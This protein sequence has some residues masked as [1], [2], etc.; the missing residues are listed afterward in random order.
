M[1]PRPAVIHC[2]SPVPE[3]VARFKTEVEG[4]DALLFV[5]PEHSRTS[6]A[7]LKNAIDWGARPWGKTSWP[8]KAAAVIGTSPGVISSAIEQQHLRAVLGNQGLHVVGSEAYIRFTPDLIDT[9]GEVS[10]ESVRKFLKSFIDRFAAF[11]G[12]FAGHAEQRAA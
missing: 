11:A 3:T 4:S 8:N 2:T 9:Q 1:M 7:V 6:R 5:T 10:D 12:R